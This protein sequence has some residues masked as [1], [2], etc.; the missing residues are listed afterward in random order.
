M[1]YQRAGYPHQLFKT[2]LTDEYVFLSVGDFVEDYGSDYK[3]NK[4][5]IG[6]IA[7]II[8]HETKDEAYAVKIAGILA[9]R[10]GVKDDFLG[11]FKTDDEWFDEHMKNM[12]EDSYEI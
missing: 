2:G 3:D 11:R 7:R 1:S 9:E 4:S 6:V 5:L 8:V 10:L 12:E